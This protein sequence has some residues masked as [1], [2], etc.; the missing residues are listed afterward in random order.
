MIE[1]RFHPTLV[2]LA[3]PFHRYTGYRHGDAIH[4]GI[5]DRK[6][7]RQILIDVDAARCCTVIQPAEA[8]AAKAFTAVIGDSSLVPP[9]HCLEVIP[10]GELA[11]GCHDLSLAVPHGFKAA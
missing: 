2:V 6:V 4:A 10:P 1:H 9:D 7:Q 3:N 5:D 8:T 11:F